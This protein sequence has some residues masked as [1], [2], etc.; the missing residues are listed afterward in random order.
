MMMKTKNE[1]RCT[2]KYRG[3]LCKRY[4]GQAENL[5]G[6]FTTKCERCN[7][8]VRIVDGIIEKVDYIKN[9]T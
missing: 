1:V 3:L 7:G 8:Q 9:K 2:G 5:K 4:L 6:V